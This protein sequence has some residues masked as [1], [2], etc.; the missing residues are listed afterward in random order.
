MKN[1]YLTT[2][3]ALLVMPL[4]S[5]ET[6]AC[7][8]R[9]VYFGRTPVLQLPRT[10]S[11]LSSTHYISY[12]LAVLRH[13]FSLPTRPIALPCAYNTPTM[14]IVYSRLVEAFVRLRTYLRNVCDRGPQITLKN[15]N[16]RVFGM[17][18]PSLRLLEVASEPICLAPA[19]NLAQVRIQRARR[20]L[21]V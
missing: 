17:Q 7:P 15:T 11:F 3:H 21:H 13:A 4:S 20:K 12:L 8:C 9:C 16:V 6:F 19:P 5:L 2:P 18:L 1:T 10:H 14:V